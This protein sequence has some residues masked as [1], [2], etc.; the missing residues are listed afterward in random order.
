MAAW[1]MAA[2]VRAALSVPGRGGRRWF[3]LTP[4]RHLG[5]RA[6]TQGRAPGNP[7]AAS[8]WPHVPTAQPK[9]R[10]TFG[11]KEFPL[12]SPGREKKPMSE[13]GGG[14]VKDRCNYEFLKPCGCRAAP[15]MTASGQRKASPCKGPM[16]SPFPLKCAFGTNF[17]TTPLPHPYCTL[18]AWS[19][20]TLCP[21]SWLTPTHSTGMHLPGPSGYREVTPWDQTAP[22]LKQPPPKH[23][24]CGC[25][26]KLLPPGWS[27]APHHCSH[28]HSHGSSPLFVWK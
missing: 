18:L 28:R 11:A 27:P 9:E 1:H 17:L 15:K 5:P 16:G 3:S 24:W 23:S 26:P 7:S 21:V 14:R 10:L 22:G 2:H 4:L 8:V 20:Q 6:P 13:T 19:T 25:P 12:V